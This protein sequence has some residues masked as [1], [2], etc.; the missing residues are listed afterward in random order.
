MECQGA[1]LPFRGGLK[2]ITDM[3]IWAPWAGAD[4]WAKFNQSGP[5]RAWPIGL[6][7]PA[8]WCCPCLLV[9]FLLL[10]LSSRPWHGCLKAEL[11]GCSLGLG[12]CGL[13]MLLFESVRLS[14]FDLWNC[15]MR[16]P[17]AKKRDTVHLN[18]CVN[19]GLDD[20]RK[21]SFSPLLCL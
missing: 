6:P 5:W 21:F 13:F 15:M 4:A 9:C 20:A 17:N 11:S 10:D 12:M 7:T 18:F 16:G 8:L 1:T 2:G 3:R 14:G 19:A